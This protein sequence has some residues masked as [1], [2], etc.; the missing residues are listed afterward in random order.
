MNGADPGGLED[1]RAAHLDDITSRCAR[2]ALPDAERQRDLFPLP[3]VGGSRPDGRPYLGRR[4]RRRVA[5]RAHRQSRLTG[6][7][8]FLKSI[9]GCAGAVGDPVNESQRVAL[10]NMSTALHRLGRPPEQHAE[11]R[12]CGGGALDE[13]LRGV[14]IYGDGAC[15]PS[16]QHRREH[17]SWPSSNKCPAGGPVGSSGR[18]RG[19]APAALA[20]PCATTA[21]GG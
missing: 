10:Q 3:L 7:I 2:G 6:A 5:L 20:E 18:R 9:Y 16:V 8:Y 17:I 12:D 1:Q 19:G 21:E 4:S 11:T 14:A 15:T 13:L